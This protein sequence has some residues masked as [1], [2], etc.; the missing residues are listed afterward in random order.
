[1]LLTEHYKVRNKLQVFK[2]NESFEGQKN[3]CTIILLRFFG[4][5]RNP[6]QK[7]GPPAEMLRVNVATDGA[8]V[9]LSDAPAHFAR[10]TRK[11][12]TATR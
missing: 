12:P 1:M 3:P 4:F 5:H 7:V 9:G 10:R 2:D 8:I 6:R 11:T